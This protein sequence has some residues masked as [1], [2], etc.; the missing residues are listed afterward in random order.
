MSFWLASASPRRRE[1]LQAL[2]YQFE[3]VDGSVDETPE[4]DECG[5]AYAIRVARTKALTGWRNSNQV[6]PVLAADTTV[7][8]GGKILGKPDTTEAATQ[9]LELLSGRV[10]RVITVV[11]VHQAE[12]QK[13][14]L[15]Q[16]F[17]RFRHL[18]S[19]DIARYIASG[20]PFDKAGA[21]GIQTGGGLLVDRVAGSY[22]SIIGLPIAETITLLK[23]FGIEPC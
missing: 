19:K 1:M 3:Y 8:L 18:R 17:V 11:C 16:A 9:M 6:Y 23:T 4:L 14:E 15:V 5:E 12:L 13:V 10:H 22:S 2:G 20:D 7:L 21:Y